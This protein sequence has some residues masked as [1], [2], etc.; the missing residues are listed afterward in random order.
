MTYD[1]MVAAAAAKHADC[2][3]A[4]GL[5]DEDI[6]RQM[7]EAAGVKGDAPHATSTLRPSPPDATV[8]GA[9]SRAATVS[10]ASDKK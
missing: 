1:E 9:A 10:G 8:S 2:R 5:T 3:M 7:L 6:A 4:G